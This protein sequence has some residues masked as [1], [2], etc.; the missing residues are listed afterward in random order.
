MGLHRQLW[1]VLRSIAGRPLRD[2]V[3]LLV[4]ALLFFAVVGPAVLALEALPTRR[5]LTVEALL[6]AALWYSF[7]RVCRRRGRSPWTGKPLP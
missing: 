4:A 5:G 3:R 6:L 7:V 2:K 1:A